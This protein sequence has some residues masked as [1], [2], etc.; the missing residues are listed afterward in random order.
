[1]KAIQTTALAV[2]AG[3]GLAATQASAQTTLTMSSWVGPSH[4]LTHTVLQGWATDV[5]KAT[6]GRVKFQMLPKAPAAPPGTFDAVRDG[7]VDVSFVT[8]SYTPARHHMPLMAELP[9]AGATAEINSVAFSRIHWKHFQQIGEY[10]GVKLLGVFTHGPGQMFTKK[11][12]NSIADIQGLKIRTGGGIAEA[13]AKSLGASA[14]VKPAPESFELMNSGVADGVFFPFESIASFKLETVIGQATLLPGGMYSSA[15]GF[16]MNEDKW[17][18]LP[19]Q[20][21][22]A[23]NKL[24]GEALARH[25]GKSWDVADKIGMDI[26]K[27]NNVKIM[28]A[29]AALVKE[30]QSRS[31]GII[32]DWVKKANTKGV[33]G[34]KVL[35]E[36]HEELK[37]VAAGK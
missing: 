1:M 10:K 30:V 12:V 25:A 16:F 32:D 17:N 24:A 9:G 27:K 26:L 33:D 37:K 2:L 21:Q 36:F 18:K 4:H 28:N 6:G 11:Q 15:F 7:L 13:V 5:E 3:L 22:D 23:I 8:A 31:A 29:D 14:F 35:A 19:K 34:A 20:D